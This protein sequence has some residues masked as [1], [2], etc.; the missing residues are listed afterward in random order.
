MLGNGKFMSY[1]KTVK[2]QFLNNPWPGQIKCIR[3]WICSVSLQFG[4]AGTDCHSWDPFHVF[5]G[6]LF[7]PTQSSGEGMSGTSVFMSR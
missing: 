4:T 3:E 2:L 6:M 5:V 7:G 1:L